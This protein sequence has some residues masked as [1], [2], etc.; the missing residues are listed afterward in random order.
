[1]FAGHGC[2]PDHLIIITSQSEPTQTQTITCAGLQQGPPEHTDV[3]EA[4]VGGMLIIPK[5]LGAPEV[6]CGGA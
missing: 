4:A 1:M 2:T 6:R 3:V 5:L